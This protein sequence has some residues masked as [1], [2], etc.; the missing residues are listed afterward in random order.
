[1]LDLGSGF[2]AERKIAERHHGVIWWRRLRI[3]TGEELVETAKS[4][5]L[6]A[7]HENNEI[8]TR[9]GL[10][11]PMGDPCA[12]SGCQRCWARN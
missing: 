5:A 10:G 12:A 1:V 6:K 2:D 3:I 7:I 4:A 9:V 11:T 8:T